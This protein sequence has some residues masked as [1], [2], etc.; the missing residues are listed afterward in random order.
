MKEV[1]TDSVQCCHSSAGWL[2]HSLA[3]AGTPALCQAQGRVLAAEQRV[4]R[5]LPSKSSLSPGQDGLHQ[6]VTR[7]HLRSRGRG[8]PKKASNP[9]QRGRGGVGGFLEEVTPELSLKGSR[10][11]EGGSGVTAGGIAFWAGVFPE[12]LQHTDSSSRGH[13]EH[14]GSWR[15]LE[16]QRQAGERSGCS[17]AEVRGR[18]WG[19]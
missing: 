9:A 16:V 10:V 6:T 5:A 18:F 1:G 14:R 13:R 19:L 17:P 4:R 15:S 7:Q 11:G 3:H 12:T 8:L 2:S